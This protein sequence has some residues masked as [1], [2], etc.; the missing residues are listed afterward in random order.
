MPVCLEHLE[1]ITLGKI[2]ADEQSINQNLYSACSRS[3]LKGALDRP[4]PSGKRT[5][6]KRA[7]TGRC[8]RCTCTLLDFGSQVFAEHLFMHIAQSLTQRHRQ[9]L[10]YRVKYDRGCCCSTNRH[11]TDM[12]SNSS[13]SSEFA[14]PWKKSCGSP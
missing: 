3:L 14:P 11:W 6:L 13:L 7:P 10:F 8:K 2:N 9:S 1:T 5:V 12:P 4:R